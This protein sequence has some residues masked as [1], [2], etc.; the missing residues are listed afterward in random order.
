LRWRDYK[1]VPD[2]QKW[3]LRLRSSRAGGCD[4]LRKNVLQLESSW[5]C[6]CGLGDVLLTYADPITVGDLE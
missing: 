1:N 4:V 3:Y 6:S 5:R 2:D